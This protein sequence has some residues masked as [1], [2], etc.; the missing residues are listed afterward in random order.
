[1][2]SYMVMVWIMRIVSIKLL[3]FMYT[4]KYSFIG[5]MMYVPNVNNNEQ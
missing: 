5:Q 1:M 4:T 2:Y 3:K